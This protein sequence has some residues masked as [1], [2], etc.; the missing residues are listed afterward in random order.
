MIFYFILLNLPK[1]MM[2][3]EFFDFDA[4]DISKIIRETMDKVIGPSI[5]DFLK[6]KHWNTTIVDEILKSLAKLDITYKFAVTCNINQSAGG[7]GL[8]TACSCFLDE[9][10]DGIVTERWDNSSLY[11]IVTVFGIST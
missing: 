2:Y 11:C 4:D 1:K 7:A 10:S 5:F 6:I 9:A 3:E 8:V